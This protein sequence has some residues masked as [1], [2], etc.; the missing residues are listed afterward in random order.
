ME[1]RDCSHKDCCIWSQ[2]ALR[3]QVVMILQD[4]PVSPETSCFFTFLS[5]IIAQSSVETIRQQTGF[6]CVT[7]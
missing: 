1:V 4:L 2:N 7:Q 5:P 3:V 6:F